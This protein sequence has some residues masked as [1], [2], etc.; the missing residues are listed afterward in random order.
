M[1]GRH[2]AGALDVFGVANNWC[3]EPENLSYRQDQLS[4]A[5]SCLVLHL[6]LQISMFR[7]SLRIFPPLSLSF[8]FHIFFLGS[9][10]RGSAGHLQLASHHGV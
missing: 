3:A 8:V 2:A 7:T 4:L 6:S 1:P 10:I 9:L 5:P